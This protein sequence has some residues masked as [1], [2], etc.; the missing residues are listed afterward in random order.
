MLIY[1]VTGVG[2]HPCC[3]CQ[4]LLGPGARSDVRQRRYHRDFRRIKALMGHRHGNQDAR[5][6]HKAQARQRL[7]RFAFIAGGHLNGIG[8]F[9][10]HPAPQDFGVTAGI[11]IDHILRSVW[12]T[13]WL[14]ARMAPAR[15][16]AL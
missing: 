15:S 8:L 2:F 6:C 11:L 10:W 16:I 7:T 9:A 4:H 1:V 5:L 14:K 13:S 12:T 3:A